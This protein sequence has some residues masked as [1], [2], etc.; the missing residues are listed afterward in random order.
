MSGAGLTAAVIG[1]DENDDDVVVVVATPLEIV[2]GAANVV[3]VIRLFAKE[4]ATKGPGFRM[5]GWKVV[6]DAELPVIKTLEGRWSAVEVFKKGA[7]SVVELRL[8]CGLAL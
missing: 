4:E 1:L 8:V 5:I 7:G 6:V 2:W 3:V